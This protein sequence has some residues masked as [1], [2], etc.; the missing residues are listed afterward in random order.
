MSDDAS[1]QGAL[2]SARREPISS[3]PYAAGSAAAR[4]WLDGWNAAEASTA[5]GLQRADA[6]FEQMKGLSDAELADVVGADDYE[7]GADHVSA[8]GRS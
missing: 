2:A 1:E 8:P 7:A 4:A 6:P 5:D 3:C